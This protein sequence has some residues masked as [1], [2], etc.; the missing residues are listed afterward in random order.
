M[1]DP[2]SRCQGVEAVTLESESFLIA[3]P[4]STSG[5]A[6]GVVDELPPNRV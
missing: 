2:K 5:A 3:S 4:G 6:F 1:A